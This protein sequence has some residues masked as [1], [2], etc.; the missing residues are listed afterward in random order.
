MMEAGAKS[1]EEG[2]ERFH[3]ISKN[4]DRWI[5]AEQA[6]ISEEKNIYREKQQWAFFRMYMDKPVKII[7]VE[8][9]SNQ[10]GSLARRH[11]QSRDQGDFVQAC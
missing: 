1:D 3:A 11:L 2:F 4:M 6:Q 5:Y 9:H 7:K 8:N 10:I